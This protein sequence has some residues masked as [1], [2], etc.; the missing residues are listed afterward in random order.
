MSL[1]LKKAAALLPL[2][3]LLLLLG[4]LTTTALAQSPT[5][6]EPAAR[7]SLED[8]LI[9]RLKAQPVSQGTLGSLNVP[10]EFL[11][12]V[13]D[14]II[15]MDYQKRFRAVASDEGTELA[16]A[17][18]DPGKGSSA[19]APSPKTAP[20]HR[21]VIG[22]GT[23]SGLAVIIIVVSRRRRQKGRK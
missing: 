10:P 23:F 13:A 8:D 19:V 11:Q 17:T 12:R 22:V 1:A 5:H 6:R 20:S 9:R 2:A 16:G 7:T 18:P 14:R 3:L 4:G 21:T 15:R